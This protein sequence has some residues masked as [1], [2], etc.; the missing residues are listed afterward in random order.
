MGMNVR[1][2]T[3]GFGGASTPMRARIPYTLALRQGLARVP[4]PLQPGS[5]RLHTACTAQATDSAVGAA[6]AEPRQDDEISHRSYETA[7][8]GPASLA[9]AAAQAGE[10]GEEPVRGASVDGPLRETEKDRG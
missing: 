1:G 4:Q 5:R 10:T 3:H 9:A 2:P 8:P 7:E 6:V